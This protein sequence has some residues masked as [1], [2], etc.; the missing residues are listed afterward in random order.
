MALIAKQGGGDFAI[1]PAGQ[2]AAVCCKII[3]L[4]HHRSEMYD[5]EAHKIRLTWELHGENQ[6]GP[7]VGNMDDGKPFLV[8]AEYTL[9]L[10]DMSRLRPML[11]SW[12]GRAFTEE[13]LEGFDIEKLL[14]APCM[15][16]VQHEQSKKGKTFAAVKSV[17]P[18]LKSIDKPV[19]VNRDV[20]FE[21][22]DSWDQSAFD[23]LPE[24]LRERIK[25]SS[26]YRAR[27]GA[28]A[29][30][31]PG[32]ATAPMIAEVPFDDDIPFEC[33]I[34]HLPMLRP[35]KSWLRLWRR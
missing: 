18:L 16:T 34:A 25:E 30:A 1:A 33:P 3:D 27:F 26:E 17:T 19:Q 8:D 22:Q 20:Y 15:L 11:E 21:M 10:S 24:W 32:A 5:K 23:A 6:V 13:E 7:G 4:G 28:S 9:S 12:R 31:K 29:Q 14:G 2:F 35:A